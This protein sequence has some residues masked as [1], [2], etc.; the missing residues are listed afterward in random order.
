MITVFESEM[1][2]QSVYDN[3]EFCSKFAIVLLDIWFTILDVPLPLCC[4]WKELFSRQIYFQLWSDNILYI[5]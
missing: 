1:L 4:S 3:V 2:I 5:S